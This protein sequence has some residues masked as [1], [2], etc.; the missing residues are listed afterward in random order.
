MLGD[1]IKRKK[2]WSSPGIDGIPNFWWKK[3]KGTWKPLV[4]SFKKWI[5]QPESI[6]DWV[7]YGR[8]V[9]LPKSEVLDDEKNYRPIT[10]LNTAYKIFTGMLGKY[11]K[12]HA[13]R[14]NI[15]DK[16][17]L[18]ACSGVLGT[19]DQLIVD[20]TIMEEVRERKRNVAVAFYDY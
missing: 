6:P 20:N 9:L 15:W 4:K 8:T 19:V 2:N 3:L 13:E 1:N 18:G 10:C 11:L 14:N 17:Q 12:E 16:S 5:D 7:T